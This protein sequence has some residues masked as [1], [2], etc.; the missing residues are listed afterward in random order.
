MTVIGYIR[1]R[2]VQGE[3]TSEQMINKY[4]RRGTRCTLRWNLRGYMSRRFGLGRVI[5]QQKIT[6]Y[7]K[8]E[9][10]TVNNK[11]LREKIV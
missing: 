6:K 7:M 3:Q 5:C 8:G 10:D 9:T 4:V 1:K 11:E 2:V